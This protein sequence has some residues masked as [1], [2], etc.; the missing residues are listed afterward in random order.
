MV[1]ILRTSYF[2]VVY[3]K[4]I[5]NNVFGTWPLIQEWKSLTLRR[6][7]MQMF[8][9]RQINL[10][11]C[12]TQKTMF[13]SH[14]LAGVHHLPSLDTFASSSWWQRSWHYLSDGKRLGWPSWPLWHA[15]YLVTMAF[16]NITSYNN[17]QGWFTK[18]KFKIIYLLLQ[19]CDFYLE[20]MNTCYTLMI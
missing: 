1:V 4:I 20:Y 8:W 11:F 5:W 6:Y 9:W 3:R 18:P 10:N 14:L 16:F 17:C 7:H 2:S 13:C 19:Q 15:L 12:V